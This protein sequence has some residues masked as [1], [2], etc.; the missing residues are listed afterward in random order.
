M[1]S[2][3]LQGLRLYQAR[4]ASP[5]SKEPRPEGVSG[6]QAKKQAK[7][8]ARQSVYV[9]GAEEIVRVSMPSKSF[10]KAH[11]MEDF[12]ALVRNCHC[13]TRDRH[14]ERSHA[15]HCPFPWIIPIL[16]LLSANCTC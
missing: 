7:A 14:F 3:L 16:K 10:L 9:E 4:A 2:Q 8:A 13:K 11:Y 12:D 6:K 15:N 5:E 1:A